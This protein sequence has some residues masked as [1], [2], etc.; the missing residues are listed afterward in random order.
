MSACSACT[1]EAE[2]AVQ[3]YSLC[4]PHGRGMM[5][6]VLTGDRTPVGYII[7]AA[8]GVP[9]V[10]YPPK[11]SAPETSEPSPFMRHGR[12]PAL[13]QPMGA[14]PISGQPMPLRAVSYR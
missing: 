7:D 13:P 11:V 6:A 14:S 9:E 12:I 4:H 10:A 2:I 3:G 8:S 1:N 5:I